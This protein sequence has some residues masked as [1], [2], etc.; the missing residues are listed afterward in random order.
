M[1]I[2]MPAFQKIGGLLTNSMAGDTAALHAAVIAINQ[3]LTSKVN[4]R[5]SIISNSPFLLIFIPFFL[6]YTIFFVFVFKGSKRHPTSASEYRGAL[7]KYQSRLHRDIL[8]DFVGSQRKES[9][10]CIEQGREKIPLFSFNPLSP[11][12]IHLFSFQS[13]NDSYVP[14]A[15]DELLTQAEIQG[16]INNVNRMQSHHTL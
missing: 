2:Q 16:H 12:F 4:N 1:G 11:S 9:T 10:S 3:S 5:F 15:Y 14:D 7:E 13:L 8:R 6:N